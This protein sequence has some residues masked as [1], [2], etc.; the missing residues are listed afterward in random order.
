[1]LISESVEII[2][3]PANKFHYL[4][5]GYDYVKGKMIMVPIEHLTLG[6]NIK[7][8]VLCDYCGEKL[9]MAYKSYNQRLKINNKI[10]CNKCKYNN[11][12][13][14]NNK[15]YDV[16]NVSQLEDTIEKIKKTKLER[17]NDVNYCNVLQIKKTKLERYNDENYCN[18]LKIKNTN[19]SR[20]GVENVFQLE[21]VKQTSQETCIKKYGVK[22]HMM[23]N[24][25]VKK[26]S[27][28]NYNRN[29]HIN[30]RNIK[31]TKNTNLNRYGVE[32]VFQSNKIKEKIKKT[33][34]RK[35]GVPHFSQ[36]DEYW[37]KFKRSIKFKEYNGIKYQSSYE[38]KF[39]IFCELNKINV[40]DNV[41][42]FEYYLDNEKH[43]YT[44]DYFI[45]HKNL[46]IEIKST[47]WLNCWLE[48]NKQKSKKVLKDGYNYLMI[49]D[50]NF[51][52]FENFIK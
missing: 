25:I 23:N 47:Y 21:E 45:E 30:Y 39:L 29:G 31:K 14:T 42:K 46:V 22:H 35:Y 44:P 16:D 43:K 1:M 33:N 24:D 36:S 13:I 50:N 6:S 17:Y 52:E 8:E 9:I 41:P 7:V 12:K 34:L 15:K 37:K 18:V 19:L 27:I 38:L 10:S 3:N 28:T 48:K 40:S 20:Y 26:C 4:E 2:F 49:L 51:S 5:K 11:T 32:N